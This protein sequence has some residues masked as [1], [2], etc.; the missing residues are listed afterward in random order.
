MAGNHLGTR[1]A[2]NES[3]LLMSHGNIYLSGPELELSV[4]SEIGQQSCM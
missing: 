1:W 2:V 3:G 4:A